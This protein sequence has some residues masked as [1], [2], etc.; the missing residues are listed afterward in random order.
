MDFLYTI[1]GTPLGFI[2]WA[3]YQL[4]HNFGISIVLFTLVTRAAMFPLN[5]KQQR[6]MAKSQLFM[7]RVQEIQTRYR[8]DQAKMQ[9]ELG[10]LQKEGYNPMGGCA[11]MVVMI[12]VL[13]GLLDVIYRPM[14]HIE[15]FEWTEKGSI[16]QVLD[17]AKSS[18]SATIIMSSPADAE[19]TAKYK[20]DPGF[21]TH[22][23]VVKLEDTPA[24]QKNKDIPLTNAERITYGEFSAAQRED[25]SGNNSK[26]SKDVISQLK[27]LDV[28]Y[29]SLQR[30]LHAITEYNRY[31]EVF[32]AAIANPEIIQKCDDLEKNMYFAGINLGEIPKLSFN[33]GVVIPILAFI[34]SV[35]QTLLTMEIQKKTMPPQMQQMGGSMKIMMLIS[36]VMSLWIT[37][38]VPA[39]AGFYWA[40]SYLLGIAQT[41]ILYKF[42]HPEKLKEEAKTALAKNNIKYKTIVEGE[43]VDTPTRVSELSKRQ[44]DEYYR[45]RLEEAHREDEAKYGPPPPDDLLP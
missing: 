36:P 39:G 6:N 1:V 26:L 2:M 34:F 44:Q 41:W 24:E 7:P 3:F 13:F 38:Q 21:F 29:S 9:E 45:K 17:I 5:L 25:I 14:T 31:P 27:A 23:G 20:Q 28:K 22:E 37:F 12:I 30:E 43:I 11:P 18:E 35:I 42:W 19:Y 16:S 15:H 32:K 33:P 8:S 4:V 40:T 10:K